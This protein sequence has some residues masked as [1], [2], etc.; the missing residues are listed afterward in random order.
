MRGRRTRGFTLLELLTVVSIIAVSA[1]LV[2]LNITRTKQR[3]TA[4]QGV[5]DLRAATERARTLSLQAGSRLGTPLVA[6]GN[7]PGA[8]GI[9]DPTR[10]WIVNTQANS[11]CVPVAVR[12]NPG[13]APGAILVDYETLVLGAGEPEYQAT[14]QLVPGIATFGFSASG[15]FT[16][17]PAGSTTLFAGL[18]NNGDNYI[19][20]FRVLPSGVV[21]DAGHQDE[22]CS[23]D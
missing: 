17:Q 3:R 18:N 23:S 6:V 12:A 2:S 19:T 22:L 8:C 10:I 13:G 11:F 4:R 14:L 1:G 9:A 21:C 20:G 5:L 7:A 16:S 15:R